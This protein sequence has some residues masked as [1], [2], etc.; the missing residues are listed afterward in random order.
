[1]MMV[2]PEQSFALLAVLIVL[3]Y[4]APAV[5]LRRQVAADDALD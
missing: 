2:H 5:V 3:G 4:L 1:M